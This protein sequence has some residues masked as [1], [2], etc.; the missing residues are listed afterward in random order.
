[1]GD[2]TTIAWTDKTWNPWMGC[3]KVSAGCLN[4]YMYRDRTRYGH[5]PAVVQRS[6]ARTFCRPLWWTAAERVFVCSCSDFFIEEADAW[7][8]YAWWIMREQAHLTFQVLT[9]R[10]ELMGDRLPSRGVPDNVWLGVTAENQEQSELRI[11]LLLQ[12]PAPVRFISAEPLLGPINLSRFLPMLDQVIVGGESGPRP[13]EMREEWARSLLRQCVLHG[14]A[15][16]MKQLSGTSPAA[17]ERIP[18]ELMIR[19]WPG[20]DGRD[21]FSYDGGGE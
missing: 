19:Q 11:P 12:V 9:K 4:C 7:R 10:P 16:F 18:A 20:Y 6:S 21:D 15:F 14:T 2:K 3:R 13:R 8:D 5:D 17:R 1:M